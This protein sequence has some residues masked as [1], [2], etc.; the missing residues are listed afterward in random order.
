MENKQFQML[1]PGHTRSWENGHPGLLTKCFNGVLGPVNPIL[2]STY[3]FMK[4]FFH[5]VMKVFPDE[6]LHLGGDEVNTKCWENNTEIVNFMQEN[7]ITDAKL[8]E[9]YYLGKIFDIVESYKPS[10]KS[11]AVWQEAYQNGQGTVA[12]NQNRPLMQIISPNFGYMVQG[13]IIAL[14]WSKNVGQK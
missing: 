14:I 12:Q 10:K 1:A 5:E 3:S 7:N 2:D 9:A 8:L 4:R 6:L 11:Y 13:Y